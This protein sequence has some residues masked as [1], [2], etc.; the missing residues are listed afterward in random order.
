MM[1]CQMPKAPAASEWDQLVTKIGALALAAGHLE[2]AIISIVCRI[3]GKTEDEI[4]IRSNKLWCEKLREVAPSSW[5]VVQKEDLSKR[6]K[7][8]RNLYL[9]RNRLIHAAVAVAGDASILGVPKGGILDL[10][11]Y[12]IGFSKRKGNTWAIG[13]IAK[14]LHLHEIDK[15]IQDV[16]NARIGLVPFME[17]ADTIKHPAKPFPAPTLGKLL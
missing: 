17:M 11:T 12:G 1:V 9:R 16:H 2:M 7:K 13:V 14:R 8:I 5:S 6:L 4:G 10:R 15:L 3:V